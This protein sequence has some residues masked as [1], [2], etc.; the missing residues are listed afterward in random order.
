MRAGA[1][2]AAGIGLF[3]SCADRPRS[4]ALQPTRLESEAAVRPSHAITGEVMLADLSRSVL[5]VR[6]PD[7]TEVDLL[8]QP[9]T[10]FE[11]LD[12]LTSLPAPG[13]IGLAR[14]K[15]QDAGHAL[16]ATILFSSDSSRRVATE[17]RY[18][19]LVRLKYTTGA[20][21]SVSHTNGVVV[22]MENG[23]PVR[24]RAGKQP[25]ISS[26]QKIG[27][28][29]P[30]SGLAPQPAAWTAVYYAEE[31]SERTFHAMEQND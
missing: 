31:G 26:G 7:G 28:F 11:D 1:M 3:A 30:E 23:V 29:G 27:T 12:G 2:V 13:S 18:H 16:S 10:R 4:A 17:V 8:I 25:V 9:S 14:L 21:R 5:L 6:K 19:S 22:L 15:D 24:Y 20:I